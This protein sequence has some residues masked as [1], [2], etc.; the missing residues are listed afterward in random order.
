M[1]IKIF[2][3]YKYLQYTCMCISV[4]LHTTLYNRKCIY[5]GFK[6][7]SPPRNFKFFY[8][9]FLIFAALDR[10]RFSGEELCCCETAL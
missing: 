2:I 6:I 4:C 9:F 10:S 5:S 8:M 1:C 7:S 3:N